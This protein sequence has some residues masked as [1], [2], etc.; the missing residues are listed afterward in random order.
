[1]RFPEGRGGTVAPGR[2]EFAIQ[3]EADLL[4]FQ[5]H[6]PQEP[7]LPGVTQLDWAVHFGRLAFPGLGAFRGVDQLKFKE[8][9]RP[10]EALVL[11]LEHDPERGR[12]RFA[13]RGAAG[14]KSSG[15]V[16]FHPEG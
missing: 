3:V 14:P 8:P 15:V 7:I 12:L 9:I 4:G 1:M 6:F 11:Q 2:A 16:R 5:G 10:G 13:L